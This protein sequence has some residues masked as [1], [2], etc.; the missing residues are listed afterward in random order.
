MGFFGPKNGVHLPV[1]NSKS[2]VKTYTLDCKPCFK[3]YFK[4]LQLTLISVQAEPWY[5]SLWKKPIHGQTITVLFGK[6]CTNIYTI[7]TLCNAPGWHSQH[8]S[9]CIR[10]QEL[11]MPEGTRKP[12][13]DGVWLSFLV[14]YKEKGY[15]QFEKANSAKGEGFSQ[16]TMNRPSCFLLQTK[17]NFVV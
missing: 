17:V 5:G 7:T 14:K 11:S 13:T 8:W 16:A 6:L 1:L 15:H 9:T 10:K 3:P 4:E 12:E 2:K